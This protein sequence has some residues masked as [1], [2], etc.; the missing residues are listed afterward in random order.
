M[1]LLRRSTVVF[2]LAT[3]SFVVG[4]GLIDPDGSVDESSPIFTS[5]SSPRLTKAADCGQL[6]DYIKSVARW[7]GS[8]LAVGG[9]VVSVATDVTA[10][11]LAADSVAESTDGEST[12]EYSS[13][14]VQEE[15]VDEPDFVKTDGRY[16]YLAS[17]GSFV[18][19]KGWPADELSE[20]SKVEV[21]GTP[22]S[23]FVNGDVAIVFSD[24]WGEAALVSG[25]FAPRSSSSVVATII[26]I[27]DRAAPDILRKISVEGSFSDARMVDGRVHF[28]VYNYPDWLYLDP[29]LLEEDNSDE[30]LLFPAMVD[31]IIGSSLP[32]KELVSTCSDTYLPAIPNGIGVMTLFSLDLTAPQG[33]LSRVSILGSPG[34]VYGSGDS[35]II[36]SYNNNSWLWWSEDGQTPEAPKTSTIL[37]RFDITGEPAYQ[38]SGEVSGWLLNQF[39]MSEYGG[40][41]R[42]ATTSPNWWSQESPVNALFVLNEVDGVYD[43]VG[44]VIGLGKVGETI[45][46][47]R[48]VGDKGY[49]VT[50]RVTD[51]LYT[52]DLSDPAAPSV[53]GSLEVPG[54]STYLH[55]VGDGH[56]LAVGVNGETGGLDISLF[57]VTDFAL[58]TL[59]ARET[60]GAGSYSE[61]QYDHKAFSYFPSLELLSIPV[62]WWSGSPWLLDTEAD[63]EFFSGLVLFDVDLATG[64]TKEGEVDHKEFYWDLA[65]NKYFYPEPVRRSFYIGDDTAGN[66]LYSVSHRGV[67]ANSLAALTQV[68]GSVKLTADPLYW[69]DVILATPATM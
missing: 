7:E 24:S 15:G 11:P 43:E 22:R 29:L 50:F 34:T 64:F 2:L 19:L 1:S 26:D 51:P 18:I 25:I 42:V 52:L 9:G 62:S 45:Q 58:P 30:T 35:I 54:F 61:A 36:A 28:L 4:C 10:A 14:N 20:L 27:S 56:L 13:T 67:K 33:V 55:P 48:M 53:V 49:V 12:P 69:Y 6:T 37:H 8:Y 46:S 63:T 16:I 65:D 44:S 60:L 38:A 66:Y 40:N 57:D 41:L 59:V 5:T 68:A 3:F 39:A 32:V 23:L 17:G 21:E 31:E 47:V